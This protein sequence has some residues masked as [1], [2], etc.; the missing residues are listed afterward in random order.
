M[1]RRNPKLDKIYDI[2]DKHGVD[3]DRDGIWEVQGTPVVKHKDVERLGAKLKIRWDE[4]KYIRA[5][6]DEAVIEVKGRMGTGP[7]ERME[8]SIGEARIVKDGEVGGNYK[9]SGKQAGYVYAM[10]EKRAKDR[11]IL[12][13]ADLHGDVYSEDEADDFKDESK[14]T[15]V[16]RSTPKNEDRGDNVVEIE[17]SKP[18]STDDGKSNAELDRGPVEDELKEKIKKAKNINAVTDLMLHADTQKILAGLPEEVRDGIRDFAKA[19]LTE[20]GWPTK[21]AAG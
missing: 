8:W 20:L 4:P 2:F 6:R 15:P 16:E 1:A 19:R 17:R 7:E 5:E 11:V 10:A 13:L 9:V 18:S 14:K 12:K 21:K 3:L